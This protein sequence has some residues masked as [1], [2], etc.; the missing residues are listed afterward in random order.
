MARPKLDDYFMEIAKVVA[1]R[2]TCLRRRAGAVL[3][4]DKRILS[5]GYNGVPK[6]LPHCEDT[7]CPRADYPSGT[8]HEL[9]RAVHSEQNAII[10]AANHGVCIEGATLYC[11]HQPCALCAKMLVNAGITRVVYHED[12]PDDGS[13]EFFR[14]AD[15]EIRKID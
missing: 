4:K 9:C 11:T 15:I 14:L 13:L 5:T 8:H 10:Q 1:S 12:Y 3:V 6:G 7:G 2:S